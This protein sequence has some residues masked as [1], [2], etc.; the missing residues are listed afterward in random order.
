MPHPPSA[1]ENVYYISLYLKTAQAISKLVCT[2]TLVEF[3]LSVRSAEALVCN[4]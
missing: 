4:L 2:E 1:V 3:L